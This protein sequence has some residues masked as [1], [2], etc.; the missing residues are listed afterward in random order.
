MPGVSGVGPPV[1]LGWTYGTGGAGLGAVIEGAL[2]GTVNEGAPLVGGAGRAPYALSM[3]A[4]R[5]GRK[6]MALQRASSVASGLGGDEQL[7]K[8][9]AS[10]ARPQARCKSALCKKSDDFMT[11]VSRAEE[12]ARV[13]PAQPSTSI[14]QMRQLE[15]KDRLF[16]LNTIFWI[17]TGELLLTVPPARC[18]SRFATA[19]VE[20]C[21][22]CLKQ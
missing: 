13:H 8:A 9:S 5:C 1:A 22:W 11:V 18:N 15:G 19:E 16:Q 4:V 20:E 21:P 17:S 12:L 14:G 7:L 3:H 10:A 6:F 2:L